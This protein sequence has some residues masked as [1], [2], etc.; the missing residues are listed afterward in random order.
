MKG[1]LKTKEFPLW[2]INQFVGSLF[3]WMSLDPRRPS[4]LYGFIEDLAM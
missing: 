4:T 1:L 3:Y 2:G